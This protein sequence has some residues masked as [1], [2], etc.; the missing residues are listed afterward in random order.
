MPRLA[1]SELA[2]ITAPGIPINNGQGVATTSTA[3][4]RDGSLLASQLTAATA[5]A[6]G[7]YQAARRSARRRIRGRSRS[8]AS[9]TPTIRANLESTGS[10]VAVIVRA[11]SPL[12]APENTSDPGALDTE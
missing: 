10:L 7:V 4:N 8:A 12:S 3:R 1:A 9:S 5:S 2:P 11:A 6:A